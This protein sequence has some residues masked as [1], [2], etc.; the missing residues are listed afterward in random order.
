MD[1]IV[2]KDIFPNWES[3]KSF[4]VDY[5]VYYKEEEYTGEKALIYY[6][7]MYRRYGNSHI[8]YD[9]EIFLE[10]LSLLI[11]ENFR[12]FFLIRNLLDV[13]AK[14]DVKELLQGV[15]TITNIADKPNITTDKNEIVNYIGMQTRSRSTENLVDRVMTSVVNIKIPEVLNEMDRYSDLFLKI[16]PRTRWIY[17]ED[18]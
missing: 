16:I 6:T 7:L 2:F 12:E 1:G 9:P 18:Y 15:E 4:L 17:E 5:S 13:L 8:A 14:T 10:Q 11:A 3:F